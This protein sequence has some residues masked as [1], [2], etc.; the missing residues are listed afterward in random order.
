MSV[1]EG[2]WIDGDTNRAGVRHINAGYGG[3]SAG[4]DHRK[5]IGRR[6]PAGDRREAHQ[7]VLRNT[8][9]K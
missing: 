5:L 8:D 9:W 3:D 7:A 4:G 6:Y 1:S 2:R